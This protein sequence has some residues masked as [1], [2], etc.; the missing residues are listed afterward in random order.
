MYL[1]DA[2]Q[3]GQERHFK[4]AIVF[5]DKALNRIEQQRPQLRHNVELQQSID[6][7]ARAV[8]FGVL[9]LIHA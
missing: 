9:L 5:L 3:A 6:K 1:Q 4:H 8:S 2:A 7:G